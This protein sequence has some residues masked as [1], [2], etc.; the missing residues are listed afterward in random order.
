MKI[1]KYQ[2]ASQGKL[3]LLSDWT[4]S[5]KQSDEFKRLTQQRQGSDTT[6]SNPSVAQ[7]RQRVRN[8]QENLKKEVS[9][10]Q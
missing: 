3:R 4:K 5:Y 9:D 7:A 8:N 2:T 6:T 10:E 1:P